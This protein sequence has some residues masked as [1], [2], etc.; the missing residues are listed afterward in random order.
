MSIVWLAAVATAMVFGFCAGRMTLGERSAE[1]I[2]PETGAAPA[3]QERSVGKAQ[4]RS[5]NAEQE[6][7]TATQERRA[8]SFWSVRAAQGVIAEKRAAAADRWTPQSNPGRDRRVR[9]Y[10]RG[11]ERTENLQIRGSQDGQRRGGG[12]IGSPVSGLVQNMWQ[13]GSRAV[14]IRPEEDRLYA[15]TGGKILKLF[16]L[17]NAF[18]FR[19]ELGVELYIQAGEGKDELLGRY[20][21]PRVVRNE[22]VG[23]GKLL[24]EFDRQGLEA[25]GISPMVSVTVES[26]MYGSDITAVAGGH[27][28]TGEEI[29]RIGQP[30]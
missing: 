23:K 22:I 9:G 8:V 17:G 6:K 27:V 21:R 12:C 7:D 28:R 30:G 10:Y 4:E 11:N 3:G 2:V 16:P 13:E 24:L 15:P 20:Y 25:E 5:A 19:T 1:E 14:V 26:S 18:L 29:L